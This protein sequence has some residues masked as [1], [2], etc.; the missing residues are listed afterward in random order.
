MKKY[1][2]ESIRNLGMFSHGGEGKTSIVEAMLFL[3]GEN[4]RLGRVDDGTSLMDYEPE[5]ME[6]KASI[7]ASLA[8]FDWSKYKINL[9]DT[10]GDDNFIYD[11]KLCM[12]VVDG[13][14]IVVSAVS[15]VRVQTE[16]VWEYA[17][18]NNVPVCFFVNKMD[19]ERADFARTIDDLQKSF[20]DKSI[21]PI[22]IPIG[23]EESFK[24][25]VDLIA[26]QAYIFKDDQSGAFDKVDIPADLAGSE[27]ASQSRHTWLKKL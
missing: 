8:V 6:R 5:E 26:M 2:T 23:Q 14:V 27:A 7:S 24:G 19:R 20:A 22:Q 15:G 3:A 25:I 12:R 13:A 1:E 4:T 11:A 18:E 10:P 9:I 17:H 16:K 21:V